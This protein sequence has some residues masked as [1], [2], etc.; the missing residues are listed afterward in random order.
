MTNTR[1]PFKSTAEWPFESLGLV[2]STVG[3]ILQLNPVFVL[4]AK[5]SY[6]ITRLVTKHATYPETHH[7]LLD[8]SKICTPMTD[9]NSWS[10]PPITYWWKIGRQN[11]HSWIYSFGHIKLERMHITEEYQNSML[12]HHTILEPTQIAV[13]WPFDFKSTPFGISPRKLSAKKTG[14]SPWTPE[15]S[16]KDHNKRRQIYTLN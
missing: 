16:R 15:R 6:R 1:S 3:F 7:S 8:L 2:P 12:N 5:K 9:V 10:A 4:L 14:A 11:I 13:S